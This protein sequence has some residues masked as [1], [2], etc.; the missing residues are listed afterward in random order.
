MLPCCVSALSHTFV[1]RPGDHVIWKSE[2]Q[3]RAA[4]IQYVNATERVASIRYSDTSST[5]L[6]SV[7][8]LDPH[9]TGDL[10]IVVPHSSLGVRRGDFV[11]VHREGTTNGLE[12]PRVPKIGEV[13]AWVRETPMTTDGHLAGWRR[14]M[15][16]IGAQIATN[17]RPGLD[18]GGK[19]R[20]PLTEDTSHSWCGEVTGVNMLMIY[21]F[22]A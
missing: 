21:I 2:D 19:V 18:V 1:I 7:L 11:F 5:E 16:E 6:A 22:T 3:Q 8:E 20:R 4:V 12:K 13:E 15:A 9:G 14:E 17:R 10:S